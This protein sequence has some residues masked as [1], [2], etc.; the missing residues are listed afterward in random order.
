MRFAL[1]KF[2]LQ[3]WLADRHV[4]HGRS[5]PAHRLVADVDGQGGCARRSG[6]GRG[7]T[8]CAIGIADRVLF[9]RSGGPL[10]CT[11]ATD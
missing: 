4:I 8:P 2:G 11:A 5:R 7:C 3:S 10:R 1:L 6:N 9:L